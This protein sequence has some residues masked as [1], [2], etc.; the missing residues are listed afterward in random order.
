MLR[1]KR[2]PA[3]PQPAGH[4]TTL[5]AHVRS[6]DRM[7]RAGLPTRGQMQDSY[8]ALAALVFGICLVLACAALWGQALQLRGLRDENDAL[9]DKLRFTT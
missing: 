7:S 2:S 4:R 1:T 6:S 5:K 9:R 3:T 8:F